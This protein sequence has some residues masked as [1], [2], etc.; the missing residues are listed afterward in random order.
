MG[1][2]SSSSSVA[3]PAG[4][5]GPVVK[6]HDHG[7]LR[8]ESGDSLLT[9]KLQ[10]LLLEH[11]DLLSGGASGPPS[12]GGG[13]SGWPSRREQQHC[14]H[15]SDSLCGRQP[16][17]LYPP[18]E[19]A[20]RQVQMLLDRAVEYNS[21]QHRQCAAEASEFIIRSLPLLHVN[22]TL[23]RLVR[24]ILGLGKWYTEHLHG[25]K[26]WGPLRHGTVA[27][28][29]FVGERLHVHE[30]V[31]HDLGLR[32]GGYEATTEPL[33]MPTSTVATPV[34]SASLRLRQSFVPPA[35]RGREAFTGNITSDLDLE[36]TYVHVLRLVALA[37]DAQFKAAVGDA[38]GDLLSDGGVG[39]TGIK[40][41]ERMVSRMLHDKHVRFLAKPRPAFNVDVVRCL[42]SFRTPDDQLEAYRRLE[43]HFGPFL[44]FDNGMAWS[45]QLAAARFHLR[46]VAATVR[47]SHPGAATLGELRS[48]PEV[49]RVWASYLAEQPVPIGESHETWHRRVERALAWLADMPADTP[50][51]MPCEVLLMPRAYRQAR[52]AMHEARRIGRPATESELAR[53]FERHTRAAAARREFEADGSTPLKR[54]CRDGDVEALKVVLNAAGVLPMT[55]TTTTTPSAGAG[56][57]GGGEGG[58]VVS[59]AAAAVAAAVAAG[60]GLPPIRLPSI[61]GGGGGGREGGGGDSGVTA[62]GAPPPAL[63]PAAT[64][65]VGAHD[66]KENHVDRARAG[67][68]DT[69]QRSKDEKGK[70]PKK[71]L[72]SLKKP[73]G[74]GG[75]K[76]AAAKGGR[77]ASSS[78]SSST[79]PT[80]SSS[81]SSGTTTAAAA[82]AAATAAATVA[83]SSAPFAPAA[84]AAAHPT[85]YTTMAPAEVVDGLCVACA[86]VQVDCVREILSRMPPRAASLNLRGRDQSFPLWH[87]CAGAATRWAFALDEPRMTIVRGLVDRKADPD[88]RGGPCNTTPLLEMARLGRVVPIFL[89]LRARAAVNASGEDGRTALYV[90]ASEGHAGVLQVLLKFKADVEKAEVEGRTA[91]M[92]AASHNQAHALELLLKAGANA[93]RATDVGVTAVSATVRH[94]ALEALEVLLQ[95][96]ASIN[97]SQ[98]GGH[99]YQQHQHQHPQQL[100]HLDVLACESAL[101]PSSAAARRASLAI[102]GQASRTTPLMQAARRN[103]VEALGLLLR[104][105]ADVEESTEASGGATAVFV[106]VKRNSGD[107]LD[108]L[109]RVGADVNRTMRNGVT[110][111][112]LAAQHNNPAAVQRLIEAGADVNA[113]A[114]ELG[115][116]YTCAARK[117]HF[118]CLQLLLAAKAT[119]A[120]VVSDAD[121]QVVVES[122]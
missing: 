94:N 61:G 85:T 118:E 117:Q 63:V 102:A 99:H 2:A 52:E 4:P 17:P 116:P 111:L 16:A 87:A 41:Y 56:G 106:A 6:K 78:F 65:A 14:R 59:P 18:E 32:L 95:H 47:F 42:A 82:A 66:G 57:G 8:S 37:L 89:L 22:A 48:V 5:T 24:Q 3:G 96:K 69:N 67:S 121:G 26:Q 79:T 104:H 51:S 109:L 77:S 1:I 72:F 73:S 64:E 30:F 122:I 74:G 29:R 97:L 12:G 19:V 115:T 46:L 53:D 80:P 60:S 113:M 31:A 36:Y 9:S 58:G 39:T 33:P 44:Q 107:T 7:R 20:P 38:L 81:S 49:Q 68:H 88:G 120:A 11:S 103:R 75:S 84:A 28:L 105:K 50:V 112:H 15:R 119:P 92:A 34:S 45:P 91:V 114:G 23:R 54:A 90:A 62:A 71:K 86:Y 43:K 98:A 101:S 70:K 100:Q 10:R 25:L 35:C 76:H 55:T 40:S 83:A 110:P 108:L 93:N 21:P 13:G 27:Y